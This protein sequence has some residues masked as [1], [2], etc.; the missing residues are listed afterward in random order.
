MTEV[1]YPDGYS[2]PPR[3]VLIDTVF[4]R[5]SVVMLHPEYQRRWRGLMIASNGKLG[6]GGAG[7]SSAQ[8]ERVFLERHYKVTSGGC[9]AYKG[10]RYQLKAGAAHAAPPGRSFHED[11]VYGG[12]AAVDAIGDLKWAALNC[13]AYGLEQATWGGEV[14]HFQFTEFPHSVTQWQAAGSPQ[15]QKWVLPT[16]PRP[17]P[18][19][20]EPTP[21]LPPGTKRKKGGVEMMLL[22]HQSGSNSYWYSQDGGL[23]RQVVRDPKHIRSI[24]FSGVEDAV[25]GVPITMGNWG[26][27]SLLSVADL[28]AYLGR[29]TS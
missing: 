7:R 11:V 16:D 8:Q 20:P 14:W 6:I 24:V 9:C 4:A 29:A 13:E 27:C 12:A 10:Q 18:K 3:M 2:T 1:L 15:P 28:D 26:G 22:A 21:P 19:P 5:P 23:S 17:E 25:T